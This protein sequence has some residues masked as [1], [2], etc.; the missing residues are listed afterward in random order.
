MKNYL[1]EV[2]GYSKDTW[3]ARV[4]TFF[5]HER[6]RQPS[7]ALGISSYGTLQ[8]FV[9][10]NGYDMRFSALDADINTC[11][12][13]GSEIDEVRTHLSFES[14]SLCSPLPLPNNL[15]VFDI[16]FLRRFQR[17][18]PCDHRSLSQSSAFMLIAGQF[19]HVGRLL[20]H[21]DGHADVHAGDLRLL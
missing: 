5:Y 13:I 15:D 16:Y 11:V 3:E 4:H 18:A 2:A 7:M 10:N 19:P 8:R 21:R 20:N 1:W 6:A 14:Y 17:A 9:D 12:V